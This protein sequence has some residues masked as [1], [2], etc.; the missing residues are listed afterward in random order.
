MHPTSSVDMIVVGGAVVSV[1][2]PSLHL[3]RV[4]EDVESRID[5]PRHRAALTDVMVEHQAR[6]LY[7]TLS[8]GVGARMG[9]T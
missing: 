8:E 9:W 3:R 1:R 5:G 4:V 6:R 2:V 7:H